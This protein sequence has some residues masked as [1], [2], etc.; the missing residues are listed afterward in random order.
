MAVVERSL[1]PYDFSALDDR[2]VLFVQAL[3]GRFNPAARLDPLRHRWL[4]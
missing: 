3:A 1:V 4:D 2:I